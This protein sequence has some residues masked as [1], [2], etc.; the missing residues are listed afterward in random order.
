MSRKKDLWRLKL[1]RLSLGGVGC[2]G[3]GVGV[4][5]SERTAKRGGKP[6]QFHGVQVEC[7]VTAAYRVEPEDGSR[8]SL[9]HSHG[10]VICLGS[11]KL[12]AH[13]GRCGWAWIREVMAHPDQQHPACQGFW[14]TLTLGASPS[15][16]PGSAHM[17]FS[18]LSEAPPFLWTWHSGWRWTLN[19]HPCC[20]SFPSSPLILKGNLV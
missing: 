5:E 12:D 10:A 13:C 6:C 7:P 8:D 4:R 17:P 18:T 15:V 11:R 16:S 1:P 9:G 19:I 20:S 14:G 2:G 3:L